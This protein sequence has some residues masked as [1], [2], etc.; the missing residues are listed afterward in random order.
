MIES[1]L[2]LFPEQLKYL[3]LDLRQ[4]SFYHNAHYVLP[5]SRRYILTERGPRQYHSV[6]NG[7][8]EL[9]EI[10]KDHKLRINHGYG[11]VYITTLMVKFL[12][13]IANKA[14]SLDP[15][16][17]GIEMEADKPNWYDALNGLPGLLGSSLSET[18]E[19]KRLAL[20]LLNSLKQLSAPESV[21]IFVELYDFIGAINQILI[22]ESDP[23]IYWQKAN[24]AKEYYRERIHRGIDGNEKEMS[25]ADVRRFLEGVIDRVN[26]AVSAAPGQNGLYPTYF[27]HSIEQ[28]ELAEASG[29]S[30]YRQVRPQKF[31]CHTLPLFLEGFVH[32]LRVQGDNGQAKVIYEQVKESPLF[33]KKLKMYKVNADLSKETEEIG[34]TRIFPRGWL[35]NESIWLHME[36]KFLLELLRN[37]LYEEFYE[38]FKDTLIPFLA[39]EKYG[40]NILENSSFIVSSAHEDKNLHGRGYV[41]RLSGSTA[42]FLHMWLLMNVGAN[43]FSADAKGRVSLTFRP[44]LPGW[45]FTK[46]ESVVRFKGKDS[47]WQNI[48]LAKNSY[49]FN[50]LGSTLVVYHNPGRKNT[51]GQGKAQ[52]QKIEIRYPNGK[53]PVVLSQ[54]G[55]PQP[56]IEDIRS[57]KAER[58]DVFF[59]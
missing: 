20:F 19:L 18:F 31:R 41:A 56:H 3:L 46:E 35:E 2:G 49:A 1:Y 47:T 48:K 58:I 53:K 10:I 12:C 32:A 13:L 44:A 21:G 24:D 33:D 7:T 26:K 34:R 39:P 16:G 43:P 37:G 50:F 23:L 55:I 4:F 5:R 45:L 15:S 22:S 40:R 30:T 29:H 57:G 51:Y 52:I 27:Y 28:Y 17:R 42:E 9:K 54:A 14:A 59:S 6:F 25:I 11:P 8:K 38:N 36:Y